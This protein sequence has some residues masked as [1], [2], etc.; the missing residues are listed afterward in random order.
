ME[1]ARK[2]VE[3]KLPAMKN[4]LHH[5]QPNIYAIPERLD[6]SIAIITFMMCLWLISK[7]WIQKRMEVK[8]TQVLP[9]YSLQFSK[10]YQSGW[11]ED[12]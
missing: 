9:P 7:E 10:I 3:D 8:V 11:L 2:R 12:H 1:M 6:N 4:V 5:R